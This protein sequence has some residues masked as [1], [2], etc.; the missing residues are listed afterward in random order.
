M[1]EIL[2]SN[3]LLN[4]EKLYCKYIKFKVDYV[5][6]KRVMLKIINWYYFPKSDEIPKHLKSIIEV[7][8]QYENEIK[9]PEKEL[10][11]DHVLSIIRSDL[12]TLDYLVEKGKKTTDKIK[13]P[14]LFGLNGEIEK[15]F[16]ADA[17]NA[18]CKTVIEVEP[19]RAVVNYQFLKDLFQACMMVKMEYLVTAVRNIYK[20]S[21]DFDKVST[22]Y[23]LN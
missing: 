6:I 22:F 10:L 1:F 18:A 20:K 14:V 5:W 4:P 7:F 11:S 13:V 16:D 3:D 2:S 9:S 12:E 17:Y 15:H 23:K 8:K 19:G 21:A